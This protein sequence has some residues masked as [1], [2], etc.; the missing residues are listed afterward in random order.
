MLVEAAGPL[1]K[2][3]SLQLDIIGDG[4][5]MSDVRKCVERDGLSSGVRL[6]GWVAHEHV[7]Q[8]LAEADVLAFPSIREFGGAVA[9]EAMAVGLVPIVVDYGGPA[10]LVTE[11]TGFRI[12]MG[13]RQQIVERLRSLLGELTMDPARIDPMGEA[14]VRR[15]HA[16]FTWDAKARQV[17][18]VYRWVI[19]E[20]A[21]PDYGMPLC[22][23]SCGELA[24]RACGAPR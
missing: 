24:W 3:G 8:C 1:V 6:R 15:A 20:R 16:C 10:E 7:Q 17:L 21:K 4:P 14:A 18:G 12:P 23:V 11:Q 19:G 5:M 2:D 9:L 13:S 22:D